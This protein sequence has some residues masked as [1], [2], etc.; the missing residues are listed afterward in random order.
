M[1][2]APHTLSASAVWE[3]WADLVQGLKGNF[4][5]QISKRGHKNPIKISSEKPRV[6]ANLR[7]R[8]PTNMTSV[9]RL[10]NT[11]T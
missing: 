4:K 7:G 11:Q 5:T 9:E 10:S 2:Q 1:R 3:G 6:Y 8:R